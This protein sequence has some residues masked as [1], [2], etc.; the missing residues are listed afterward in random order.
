MLGK[1]GYLLDVVVDHHERHSTSEEDGLDDGDED[2]RRC[3]LEETV[4]HL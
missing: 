4:T 3:Q 1:C 2:E